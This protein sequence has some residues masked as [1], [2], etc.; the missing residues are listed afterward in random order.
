MGFKTK[1]VGWD[2]SF[3]MVCRNYNKPLWIVIKDKKRIKKWRQ[4]IKN[5]IE[6][7]PQKEFSSKARK[8]MADII[9]KND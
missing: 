1:N 9:C 2:L 5:G 8:I 7:S 3:D 6:L 4:Q